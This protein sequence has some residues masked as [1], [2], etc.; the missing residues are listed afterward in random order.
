MDIPL[1]NKPEWLKASNPNAS[2]KDKGFGN[3][4]YKRNP[5]EY[6]LA[7]LL[8][9][10]VPIF[11]QR[12]LEAMIRKFHDVN[13]FPVSRERIPEHVEVKEGLSLGTTRSARELTAVAT[14]PASRMV[15]G[16]GIQTENP[17]QP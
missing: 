2:V 3:T 8:E 17:R 6:E 7:V 4:L 5:R 11:A 14:T 9:S 15:R 12:P 13:L 1:R 10:L 16:L